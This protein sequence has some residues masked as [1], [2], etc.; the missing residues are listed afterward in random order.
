LALLKSCWGQNKARPVCWPEL[1]S[2]T[3]CIQTA[4]HFCPALS[5]SGC[6]VAYLLAPPARG[7]LARRAA[8]APA[9]GVV[10]VAVRAALAAVAAR[11][12][13]VAGS[14]VGRAIA[15]AIDASY[16]ITIIWAGVPRLA[17]I[18]LLLFYCNSTYSYSF[19]IY[20]EADVTILFS[21]RNGQYKR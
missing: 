9:L 19:Y 17:I 1:R 13:V 12:L 6:I 10:A 14:T 4:R 7:A 2:T 11:A 16:P 20:K 3:E 21:I 18:Y 15:I 5:Q 8:R